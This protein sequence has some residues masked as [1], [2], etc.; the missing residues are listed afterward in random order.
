MENYNYNQ[1]LDEE[2]TIDIKK[3]SLL[4]GVEGF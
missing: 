2:L 3:Y 1:E 4:C